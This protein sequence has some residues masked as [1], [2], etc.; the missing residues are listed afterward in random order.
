MHLTERQSASFQVIVTV[1]KVTKVTLTNTIAGLSIRDKNLNKLSL[2][3]SHI[4]RTK[5]NFTWDEGML[6]HTKFNFMNVRGIN[7][8]K[9]Y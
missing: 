7:F 1:N 3:L 8:D 6:A 5:H 4:I 2:A 9:I